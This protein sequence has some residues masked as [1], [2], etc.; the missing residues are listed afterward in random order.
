MR[1]LDSGEFT[2]GRNKANDWVLQDPTVSGRHCSISGSNGSFI[3]TDLNSRNGLFLNGERLETGASADLQSGDRLQLGPYE[4]TVSISNSPRARAQ[5][6]EPDFEAP[7][8]PAGGNI[9]WIDKLKDAPGTG[10]LRTDI[11]DSENHDVRGHRIDDVHEDVVIQRPPVSGERI[12]KTGTNGI[13][14]DSPAKGSLLDKIRKAPPT[15]QDDSDERPEAP[16]RGTLL[17]KI[18]KGPKSDEGAEARRK[19]PPGAGSLLDKIRK[20]PGPEEVP[21]QEGKKDPAPRSKDLPIESRDQPAPR[22]VDPAVAIPDGRALA[23]AF[24]R[25][26]KLPAKTRLDD[27][28]AFLENQGVLF[29][30][31]IDGLV[32][33]LRARN[34]FKEAMKLGNTYVA[35]KDNNPLKFAPTAKKAMSMLIEPE[36]GY[37]RA[38]DAIEQ[39]F[40]DLQH[41][42]LALLAGM[43]A[44]IHGLVQ[45][46]DPKTIERSVPDAKKKGLGQL[47]NAAP[48]RAWQDY[49]RE[50]DK[51]MAD[52]EENL[53]AVIGRDF[54]PAYMAELHRLTSKT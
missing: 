49:R 43:E 16:V 10:G 37:L 51:L 2:I 53:N 27:P 42:N 25:G 19:D 52:L 29:R 35:V 5:H 6:Y 4:L 23:E 22:A 36:E 45:R 18:R 7:Q 40:A 24:L 38:D 20:G 34:I 46:L 21:S 14:N 17:D 3:V 9:S 31:L 39:A 11:A 15:T 8:K 26:A 1:T 50:Y 13:Q 32:S 41:H 12:A 54:L 30:L 47:V 28:V 48:A 44:A 33:A